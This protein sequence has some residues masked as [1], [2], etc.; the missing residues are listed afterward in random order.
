MI[1]LCGSVPVSDFTARPLADPRSGFLFAE[2]VVIHQV[3][4]CCRSASSRAGRTTS[5][6]TRKVSNVVLVML[7]EG[8][9]WWIV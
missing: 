1:E 4:V 6:S 5:P 2:Y 7:T 9:L 3:L 8:L